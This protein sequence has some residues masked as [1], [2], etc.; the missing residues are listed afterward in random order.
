MRKPNAE[1]YDHVVAAIG[2]APQRIVFFD[3]LAENIAAARER[4]LQAVHVRSSADVA[5]ALDQLG[6]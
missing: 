5:N 6:L 4:G 1:A 3:D 2:V